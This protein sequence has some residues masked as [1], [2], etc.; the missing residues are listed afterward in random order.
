MSAVFALLISFQTQAND[1]KSYGEIE[2]EPITINGLI[3]STNT[4][5]DLQ[6][7]YEIKFGRKSRGCVGFGLCVITWIEFSGDYAPENGGALVKGSKV[8][9]SEIRFDFVKSKMTP[10]TLDQ[11]FSGNTFLVE[12]AIT[13]PLEVQSKLGVTGFTI[14]P[15]NYPVIKSNDAYTVHFTK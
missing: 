7:H 3:D 9:N 4:N 11:Y 2:I 1:M 12:E 14:K 10:A 5:P 13:L 8:N 15:G 6:F